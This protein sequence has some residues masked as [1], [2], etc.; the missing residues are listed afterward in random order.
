MGI[1]VSPLGVYISGLFIGFGLCF[2]ILVILVYIVGFSS[3][4][5]STVSISINI[6]ISNFGMAL[7]PLIIS[8]LSRIIIGNSI[9]SRYFVSAAILSLIAILVYVFKEKI[10]NPSTDSWAKKDNY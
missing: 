1:S 7:A 4:S 9:Q 8:K 3:P 2:T 10:E 5:I 6:A